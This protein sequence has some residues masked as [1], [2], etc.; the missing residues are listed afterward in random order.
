M[1]PKAL[2][3]LLDASASMARGDLLDGRLRRMAATAALLVE[4][5]AGFEH[6]FVYEIS[7]HS[8]APRQEPTSQP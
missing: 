4:A 7:V 1:K 5:L 2:R 8:G 3:F 6:K